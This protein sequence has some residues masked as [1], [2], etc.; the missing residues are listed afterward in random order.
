MNVFPLLFRPKES[1][2]ERPRSWGAPR[3]GTTRL[4]GACDLYAPPGSAVVACEAGKVTLGPYPFFDGSFAIEIT[5]G[6]GRV[7]RYCEMTFLSS[8]KAGAMVAAGQQIGAV[9]WLPT[10]H[11]SMVHFEMYTGKA[12]GMLTQPNSGIYGR[13][14]D[15]VNPTPYLDACQTLRLP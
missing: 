14:S 3:L 15:L 2:H 6:D 8:L 1:Y 12:S 7:F 10:A 5:A 13:R 11:M 9:A 4:H